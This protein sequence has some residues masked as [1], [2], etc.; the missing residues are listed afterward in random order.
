MEKSQ[1]SILPENLSIYVHWPYCLSKCPYCD[2]FSKVDKRVD[3][4]KI[5]A[6]Y[7]EDLRFYHDLTAD[8]RVQSVFFGGGTPSLIAPR[9]I[10]KIIDCVNELWSCQDK[11]EISL[12]A[13]PNTNHKNLFSELRKAGINRLSLG[14]Q[15]LNNQDLLFLGR[16]HNLTQALQAIEE[17]VSVFDNHS[18]DL[19]YARPNQELNQWQSELEQVT[20][21]GLKHISLYQ[22]TIE[23]G[24]VFARKGIE[25]LEEEKAARMYA[26]TQQFLKEKGYPQ[27]EI[28][29]FAHEGYQSIHNLAYWRGE[30]YVGIGPSA[31]G[32]LHLGNKILATTYHLQ[33][34]ELSPRERAEELIIMGLRIVE[35]IDKKRFYRQCGLN[36]DKFVNQKALVDLETKGYLQ[37]NDLTLKATPKGFL[38]LDK[39]IEEL[40]S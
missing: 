29:N 15:A 31:H 30:D 14:V 11:V 10:E 13:N 3:Q 19:I 23:E 40:C 20:N 12:E 22:L 37:N 17:V 36:F 2:F 26:F 18:V 6:S 24:T 16:T 34:E 27:Y 35:G 7:L 33:Q 38:V 39:L 9:N 4:D 21:F 1:Q 5:I 25:P 8:K 28:S 32:R